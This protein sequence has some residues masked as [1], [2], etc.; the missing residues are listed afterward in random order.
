MK[1]D[2]CWSI[3]IWSTAGNQ[4]DLLGLS[5]AITHDRTLIH[6]LSFPLFPLNLFMVAYDQIV[7]D[8]NTVKTVGNDLKPFETV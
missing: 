4:Q 6:K 7:D 3:F 8:A 1:F 2:P 5:H